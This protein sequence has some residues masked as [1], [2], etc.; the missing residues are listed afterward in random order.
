LVDA[1]ADAEEILYLAEEAYMR[2]H[3]P[4]ADWEHLPTADYETYA[5]E[6]AWAAAEEA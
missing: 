1:D 5:N 2:R 3:G 4:D 6:A